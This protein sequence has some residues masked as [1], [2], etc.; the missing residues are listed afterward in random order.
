MSLLSRTPTLRS[1]R[2]AGDPLAER[3]R[4]AAVDGDPA[5]LATVLDEVGSEW[6]RRDR[7][8]AAAAEVDDGRWADAWVA[9]EPGSGCAHTVA[10]AVSCAEAWRARGRGRGHE[11]GDD[12][13]DGWFAALERAEDLLARAVQLDPD[14]PTPW[15]YGLLTARGL[16]LPAE[17]RRA[18]YAQLRRDPLHRHGHWQAVRGASPQWGGSREELLALGEEATRGAPDGAGVHAVWP[19]L[20]V[21]LWRWLPM[22]DPPD[23]A[24][25]EAYWRDPEVRRQVLG[26]WE[27]YAAAPA[28]QPAWEADDTNLFAFCLW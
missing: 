5:A 23:E 9:A 3:A 4:Q 6:D 12:E 18:R 8:V 10:A 25:A 14:D 28:R 24:A 27:R 11:L 1:T 20:H 2:A 16:Q 26:A 17:E 7:C 15:A 19:E 21:E 13:V 22:Q